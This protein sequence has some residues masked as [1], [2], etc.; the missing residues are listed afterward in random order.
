MPG[1]VNHR[2]MPD[3]YARADTVVVASR[4]ESFGLVVLEALACGIPVAST[5]VG[6][7]PEVIRPGVN[8]YLARP[9][10]V[11]GLARA[12]ENALHLAGEQDPAAIRETVAGFDWTVAADRL[13]AVYADAADV[14][15]ERGKG[16][17]P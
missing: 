15:P 11:D 1:R 6:V 13:L 4:Y 3:R 14:I 2:E 16:N 17:P 7:A 8:G 12:I 5:E 9:G 10:D